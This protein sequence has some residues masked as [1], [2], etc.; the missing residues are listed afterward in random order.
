MKLQNS[1]SHRQQVAKSKLEIRLFRG[2]NG[3]PIACTPETG[4]PVSPR[5]VP[6]FRL[7]FDSSPILFIQL[8]GEAQY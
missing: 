7:R 3:T 4:T 8:A 6:H 2:L 5:Q 1:E